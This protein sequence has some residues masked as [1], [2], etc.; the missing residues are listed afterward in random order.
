M[1]GS[2]LTSTSTT[3]ACMDFALWGFIYFLFFCKCL[4]YKIELMDAACNENIFEVQL[5]RNRHSQPVT[6]AWH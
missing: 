3:I 1:R 5:S 4:N 2:I 6:V